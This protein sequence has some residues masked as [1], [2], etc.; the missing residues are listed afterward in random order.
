MFK[1]AEVTHYYSLNQS[2][3]R[4]TEIDNIEAWS[5]ANNLTLNRGKTVEVNFRDKNSKRSATTPASIPGI[6]RSSTLKSLGVMVTNTLSM[7]EHIH[8]II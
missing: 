4:F 2:H 8:G 5:K 3:T 7:A 1:M 6:C